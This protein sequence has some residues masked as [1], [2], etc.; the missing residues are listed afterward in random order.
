ML[1]FRQQSNKERNNFSIAK[2]N[3]LDAI[4]SSHFNSQ[5]GNTMTDRPPKTS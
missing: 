3:D 4:A 5:T 2:V 1:I